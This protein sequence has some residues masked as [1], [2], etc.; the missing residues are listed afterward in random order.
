[1]CDGRS[2]QVGECGSGTTPS[3][4]IS[5]NGDLCFCNIGYVA[6]PCIG[7]ENWGGAGT[8]TCYGPTQTLNV[9]CE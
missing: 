6:R 2:W 3:I 8:D 5:A 4:E 9:K 1:V 7:N